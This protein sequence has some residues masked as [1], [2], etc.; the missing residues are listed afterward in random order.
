MRAVLRRINLKGVDMT[1]RKAL[2]LAVCAGAICVPW[3]A[4]AA[5]AQWN[6]AAMLNEAWER[7]Y[8]DIK[9]PQIDGSATGGFHAKYFAI[10]GS[11]SYTKYRRYVGGALQAPVLVEQ[12]GFRANGDICE[13]LN[14]TIHMVWEDWNRES[15]QVGWARSTN[16]GASWSYSTITTIG[17]TKHPQIAPF[18]FAPNPD[19]VMSFWQAKQNLMYYS[20]YNGSTWPAVASFASANSEYQVVGTCR[21]PND[22]SVWRAYGN[23]IGGTTWPIAK[24]YNGAGWDAEVPVE[25]TG[26]FARQSVAA[27]MAGQLMYVWERDEVFY[28][29]LYTPGSG[30]GARQTIQTYAGH[31]LVVAIPGTTNFYAVYVCGPNMSNTRIRVR[32]K[33]WTGSSWGP[34][35]VVSNGLPDAFTVDAQVAAGPD[36]T[37]YACWEYWGGANAPNAY[38]SVRPA[39]GGGPQGTLTGVVRD[40]YGAGVAGATVALGTG[41]STLTGAGGAYSFQ[42]PVGTHLVLANKPY[43]NG[44]SRSNIT[45]AQNQTVTVDLAI[46][47]MAPTPAYSLSAVPTGNALRLRWHRSDS[48]NSSGTVIRYSTTGYPTTPTDG[49][50]L[51]DVPGPPSG[52]DTLDHTGVPVGVRHYYAAFAYFSDA[53][54][55][56][57]TSGATAIGLRP[58]PADFDEDGDVDLA[59]FAKFQMCFNGPNQPPALPG[60]CDGVDLDGDGDADLSD[61]AIYSGCFNGPNRLPVTGCTP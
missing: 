50:L 43:Y 38:Y 8:G 58:A 37:L 53:S 5:R 24:R 10:S 17:D 26:F 14:G 46:S 20:R 29:K 54:R 6:T 42:V 4:S 31:G 47:A 55:H 61:F 32:G 44:D 34:E 30:W 12:S 60:S 16:G 9:T 45:V 1:T 13:G 33:M 18:G 39:P 7:G 35:E 59:D 15:P 49:A 27:N 3:Y 36:G 22:G 23:P 48:A 56:Y 2:P 25:N 51:A 19:I 11:G 40:Q 41:L 28:S 57:A 21:S 52:W